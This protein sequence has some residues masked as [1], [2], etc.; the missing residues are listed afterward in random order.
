MTLQQINRMGQPRFVETLGSVFEDSSWVA[1]GTWHDRPFAS[2]DELHIRMVAEVSGASRDQQLA[3]L[4]AHP[5]VGTRAKMSASSQQEQSGAGL[6]K[7][8]EADYNRLLGMNATY[9]EKFG[10][11][12]IYAVKGSGPSAILEALERGLAAEPD[13]E[14]KHALAQVYR[15]ACFRLE[16]V[17]A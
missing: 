9:K 11:P 7:L 13:A 17:I 3:L 8:T 2:L 4:R 15:I 5:D 14:F 12:F 10:F 1:E 16:E 6:D